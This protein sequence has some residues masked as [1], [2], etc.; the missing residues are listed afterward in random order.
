MF[1]QKQ[2]H[3]VNFYQSTLAVAGGGGCKTSLDVEKQSVMGW[4]VDQGQYQL[5]LSQA[6]SQEPFETGMTGNHN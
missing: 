2:F 6:V 3:L 4:S 5:L 1:T